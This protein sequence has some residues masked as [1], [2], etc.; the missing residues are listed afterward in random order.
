M[1]WCFVRKYSEVF[2]WLDSDMA[3]F[4]NSTGGIRNRLCLS[5][6]SIHPSTGLHVHQARSVEPCSSVLR[7]ANTLTYFD[8][9]NWEKAHSIRPEPFGLEPLGHELE[10]EW[11]TAE[12]LMAEGSTKP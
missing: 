10:A 1:P 6:R 12:R 2:F 9:R 4:G 7:F 11:L 8:E 5:S 3:I